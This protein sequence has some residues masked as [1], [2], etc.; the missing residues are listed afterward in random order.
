MRVRNVWGS[1]TKGVGFGTRAAWAGERVDST[2][3][4]VASVVAER[5]WRRV[6]DAHTKGVRVLKRGVDDVRRVVGRRRAIVEAEE[7]ECCFRRASATQLG[8]KVLSK[9][10]V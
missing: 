3:E 4:S 10:E 8:S 2:G 1:G 5:A 7:R 6:Q 9:L